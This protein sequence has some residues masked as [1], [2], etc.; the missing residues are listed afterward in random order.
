M[1]IHIIHLQP[2]LILGKA[3]KWA[4]FLC[5]GDSMSLFISRKTLK[6][7]IAIFSVLQN[8]EG[9]E[10]RQSFSL[11]KVMHMPCTTIA[12]VCVAACWR[13]DWL[14]EIMFHS[15]VHKL[16]RNAMQWIPH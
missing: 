11:F 8:I 2:S 12:F 4:F 9:L 15:P 16:E 7:F 10:K 5:G 1:K 6:A 14:T 13:V 3:A